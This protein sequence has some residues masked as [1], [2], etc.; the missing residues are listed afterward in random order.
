MRTGQKQELL[1][2]ELPLGVKL[3]R[4]VQLFELKYGNLHQ[5]TAHLKQGE[6]VTVEEIQ[7]LGNCQ[8]IFQAAKVCVGPKVY[9]ASAY[10]LNL[11]SRIVQH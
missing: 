11:A 7:L 10:E 4:N 1:G 8:D 6:L 5:A 3:T 2:Q 9:W